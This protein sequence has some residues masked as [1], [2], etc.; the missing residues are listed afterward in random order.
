MTD[1]L[2]D[3]EAR[4]GASDRDRDAWLAERRQ[5]ITATE[6]RDLYLGKTTVQDLIDLKLGR[7][8]DSFTGNVYTRWGTN[9][10]PAIA[11]TL[12]G[13]GFEPESRVFHHPRNSRYLASPDGI[14]QTFDGEIEI[15]EIKTAATDLPPGSEALANKGYVPQ[16]QWG[17]F[18]LGAARAR[19]AVEERHGGPGEFVPGPLHLHWIE[20]DDALIEKLVT[21]ADGFLTALDAQREDGA[22]VIDEELDTHAVNYLRALDLEKQAKALKAPAWAAMLAAGKSQTSALA[23]ITYKAPADVEVEEIDYDA[24]RA[25]EEGAALHAAFQAASDAW[26]TYCDQ[27]KT[28]K[29][30]PGKPTLR[31]TPVKTK[32]S[33]R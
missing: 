18:V 21:I 7:K 28:T 15:A 30:V 1:L 2:L 23:R 27:F 14:R 16:V 8:T 33:H 26:H 10:E 24:A 12:A 29:T 13:E 5:G 3:L 11:A 22:P 6:V 31:V 25:T 17:M 20:R 32:E 19:F 9:R 4:A